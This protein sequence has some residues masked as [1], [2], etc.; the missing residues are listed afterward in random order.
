MK[1][2]IILAVMAVALGG[3]TWA[4]SKFWSFDDLPLN[5]SP[6][7]WKTMSATTSGAPQVTGD[8]KPT[9]EYLVVKNATGPGARAD[10]RIVRVDDT[11]TTD[12]GAGHHLWTEAVA[13][14][15]GTIEC[16]IMADRDCRTVSMIFRGCR[17]S[18]L[19]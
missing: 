18:L 3:N 7:G 12:Y 10:N 15:D 19:R 2:T 9:V 8:G 6:A 4:G 1:K 11:K 16:H 17:W 5:A 14:T 13:F